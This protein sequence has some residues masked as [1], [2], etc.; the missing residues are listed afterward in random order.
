MAVFRKLATV[1]LEIEVYNQSNQ[2]V[3]PATS[4]KITV[5]NSSVNRIEV[6][7]ADMVKDSTGKYHYDFQTANAGRGDYGVTFID[8][9]GSRISCG[10]DRFTLE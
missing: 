8:T 6:D 10:D 7:S 2:L 9:D 4:M 1:I 5:N 3:D